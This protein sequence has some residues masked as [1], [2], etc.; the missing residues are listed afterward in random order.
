MR[1]VGIFL[2]LLGLAIA[3]FG[4]IKYSYDRSEL[5][6]LEEERRGVS[7]PVTRM[8]QIEEKRSAMK[9]DITMTVI[10]VIGLAAGVV[11]VVLP[12]KKAGTAA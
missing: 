5:R 8:R 4:G 6:R 7:A 12:R 10:G 3:L 9:S 2:I 1:S 11:L